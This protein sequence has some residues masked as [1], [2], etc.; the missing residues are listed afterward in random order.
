MQEQMR[1]QYKISDRKREC[2]RSR[3]RP[4]S[5]VDNIKSILRNEC[6]K[7]WIQMAQH[8]V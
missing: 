1:N 5:E 8:R 3:R 7:D 6:I 4:T 2:K